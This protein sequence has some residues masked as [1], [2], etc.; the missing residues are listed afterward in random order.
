MALT[1]AHASSAVVWP[2]TTTPPSVAVAADCTRRRRRFGDSGRTRA[3]YTSASGRPQP[4]LFSP[5]YD[6][7]LVKIP[8]T[9]AGERGRRAGSPPA[10]ARRAP[11]TR[12]MSMKNA[13]AGSE[14]APSADQGTA[15]AARGEACVAPSPR[16]RAA[17]QFPRT[18]AQVFLVSGSATSRTRTANVA[19]AGACANAAPRG[20]VSR[21]RRPRESVATKARGPNPGTRRVPSRRG[22]LVSA[23]RSMSESVRPRRRRRRRSRHR[24]R[25]DSAR[26]GSP[27]T[28]AR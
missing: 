15:N 22:R 24:N 21:K 4:C 5:S 8:R 14:K 17:A 19:R 9:A 20:A 27:R 12:R 2:S 7:F 18:H 1:K 28:R 3:E 11:S 13:R 26:R 10:R 6:P 16:H 25:R 23:S